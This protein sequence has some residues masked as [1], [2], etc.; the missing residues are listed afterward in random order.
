MKK[1]LLICFIT[2]IFLTACHEEV[3]TLKE[4]NYFKDLP[5]ENI[6]KVK[7]IRYTEAGSNIKEETTK[8]EINRIYNMVNNIK[9]GKETNMACEDNTTIYAFYIDT[10]EKASIQ[11]EC[12]WI[13]LDG[14]RYL[15]K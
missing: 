5:K 9:I 7:I 13:I 6:T 12:D 1:K 10:E 11:I 3:K 14:K 8:E 4:L 15:I 2:I